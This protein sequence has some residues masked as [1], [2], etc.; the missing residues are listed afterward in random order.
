MIWKPKSRA[1]EE[2]VGRKLHQEGAHVKIEN[3]KCGYRVL[4]YPWDSPEALDTQR[5]NCHCC[6]PY[7]SAETVAMSNCRKKAWVVESEQ[8]VTKALFILW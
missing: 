6:V 4:W 3:Q 2:E 5:S 1:W 7:W 8:L